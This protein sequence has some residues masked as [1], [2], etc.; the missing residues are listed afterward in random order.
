[1]KKSQRS[2]PS[3]NPLFPAYTPVP[4]WGA[5]SSSASLDLLLSLSS[6]SSPSS[7][8]WNESG[9]IFL[10]VNLQVQ[11]STP[12]SLRA[13]LP[14]LGAVANLLL[15]WIC[16]CCP[17][18]P[19]D[20]RVDKKNHENQSIFKFKH[21]PILP[22][23][24]TCGDLGWLLIFCFFGFVLL[25]FFFT[26]SIVFELLQSGIFMR[27]WLT[28]MTTTTN[29][30]WNFEITFSQRFTITTRMKHKRKENET[31]ERK[32]ERDSK[33]MQAWE[34]DYT[35]VEPK[36]PT[37]RSEEASSWTHTGERDAIFSMMSWA[38]RS[39]APT[40][41]ARSPRLKRITPIFPR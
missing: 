34:N 39:P 10:N 37:P 3:I 29:A 17:L 35:P 7:S 4:P 23:I 27:H 20:M 21:Q 12:S 40:S 2:S 9:K 32:K 11:I 14:C 22:W 19:D 5:H 24:H 25:N 33:E 28:T 18:H 6:F 31:N 1:M 30:I 41:K 16:H 38:I 36:P 13:H 15:L 8:W 26:V